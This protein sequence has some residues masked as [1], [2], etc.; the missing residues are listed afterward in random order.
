MNSRERRRGV[1]GGLGVKGFRDGMVEA[2]FRGW[3][4]GGEDWKGE[5]KGRTT[6]IYF[7]SPQRGCFKNLLSIGRGKS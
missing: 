4:E 6:I 3:V 2:E 7:S 1:R 5:K